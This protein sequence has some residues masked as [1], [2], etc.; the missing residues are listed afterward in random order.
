MSSEKQR[1][2][3]MFTLF[4]F[5]ARCF[6]LHQ[7]VFNAEA[8]EFHFDPVTSGR[9]SNFVK[10]K[11]RFLEVRRYASTTVPEFIDCAMRCLMASPACVSLNIASEFDGDGMFWCELLL[12][13]IYNNTQSLKENSTSHHFSKWVS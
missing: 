12:G 4:S 13:D 9:Y 7:F 6:Y 5:L 8:V 2:R 10:H 11:A 1:K 3:N